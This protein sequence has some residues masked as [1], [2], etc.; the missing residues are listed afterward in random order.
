MHF[1]QK[2]FF[3]S[4]GL[5]AGVLVSS[6]SAE[7]FTIYPPAMAVMNAAKG[8]NI[9]NGIPISDAVARMESTP[10][11]G[12]DIRNDTVAPF[13]APALH[14]DAAVGITP[15]EHNGNGMPNRAA[16]STELNLLPASLSE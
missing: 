15:H 6:L 10:V 12:V 9:A 11:C 2:L 3:S 16:H 4:V 1:C 8:R 7:R 14:S 5:Y 13:E